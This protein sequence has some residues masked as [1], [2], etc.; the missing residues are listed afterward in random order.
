MESYEPWNDA[1]VV[2]GPALG[3]YNSPELRGGDFDF[4][5][6]TTLTLLY[7]CYSGTITTRM[8]C[9]L[10]Y[11]L[12]SKNTVVSVIDP[13]NKERYFG[14]SISELTHLAV[15]NVYLSTGLYNDKQYKKEANGQFVTKVDITQTPT[16]MERRKGSLYYTRIPERGALDPEATISFS[17]GS[18]TSV[19]SELSDSAG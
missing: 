10:N 2:L 12:N 17:W 11:N 18:F 1:I 3:G 9:I 14:G 4:G 8:L 16:N 15:T 13:D 19:V 7:E 5:S 6:S